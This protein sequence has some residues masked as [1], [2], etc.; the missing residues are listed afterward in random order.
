MTE[1][2]VCQACGFEA[3]D[4]GISPDLCPECGQDALLF[5]ATSEVEK[6]AE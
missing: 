4:T 1:T 6:T 2:M 3:P 5:F